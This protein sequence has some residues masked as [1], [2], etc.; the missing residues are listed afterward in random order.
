MGSVVVRAGA[1]I[2]EGIEAVRAEYDI[3]AHA[4]MIAVRE[5]CRAVGGFDLADCTL[6]TTA[7]PCWMCS[8]AVRQARLGRVVM[9]RATAVIGGAGGA[10]AILLERGVPGWAA[11]P[12]VLH[13]VLA[14]ECGCL[15]QR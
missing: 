10:H 7:E 11:P 9:G 2:A 8:F 3:A 1:L 14:D 13:G 6:Y 15:R 4:E 5:A 12:E